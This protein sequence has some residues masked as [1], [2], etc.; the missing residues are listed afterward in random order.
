MLGTVAEYFQIDGSLLGLPRFI[1]GAHIANWNIVGNHIR[2]IILA[3]FLTIFVDHSISNL[4][5]LAVIDVTVRHRHLESCLKGT[6]KLDY[7]SFS[8]NANVFYSRNLFIFL[9]QQ[10]FVCYPNVTEKPMLAF[11]AFKEVANHGKKSAWLMLE[12]D[13]RE[14]E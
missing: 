12:R 14:K 10:Q 4:Q 3:F 13:G 1:A 9:A 11:H 2:F 6:H 8:N 7:L 5:M